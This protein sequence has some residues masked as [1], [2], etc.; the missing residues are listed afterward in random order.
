MTITVDAKGTA[1]LPL[2]PGQVRGKWVEA[3][4]SGDYEQA[5]SKLQVTEVDSDSN[6]KIGFCCLGVLCDLAVRHGVIDKPIEIHETYHS[7]NEF[8][9]EVDG[10]PPAVR[11]WAGLKQADPDV[12]VPWGTVTD[13]EWWEWDHPGEEHPETEEINIAELND[14]HGFNFDQLADVIVENFGIEK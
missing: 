10:L 8:D 9:G 2:T 5:K 7:H 13:P 3:L 12:E 6:K 11:A 1:T 4:R 14:S